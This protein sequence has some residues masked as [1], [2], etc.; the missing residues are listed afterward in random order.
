MGAGVIERIPDVIRRLGLSRDVRVVCD[1]CTYEV[2]GAGVIELLERAGI[3]AKAF[4]IA[5]ADRANI[6]R[7]KAEMTEG[8]LLVAVGGGRSIDVSKVAAFEL[9]NEFLSVP[10]A[11]S[12]DGIASDRASIIEADGTKRSSSAQPPIAV[13]ADL[14]VISRSPR[15]LWVSG[16]G[17]VVSNK[18]AVLDWKLANRI[19]G[20]YL[21]HYAA[22]LSELSA[23]VL[24]GSAEVVASGTP[25]GLRILV[26][27]LVLSSVAMSIGG[28]SR[29]ASGA[30]HLFS[31]T[32]DMIASSPAMHGEQCGVGA[33]IMMYLHGGDWKRIRD[34]LSTV[35]AP[36]DAVGLG[37]DEETIVEALVTAHRINPERYTILDGGIDRKAA[38]TACRVTGVISR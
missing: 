26:K 23:E 8:T 5:S 25:E 36:V 2:A 19:Q 33:I 30:E 35:G 27:S 21:S 22:T 34:A 14:A 24:I 3:P 28:S 20:E 32:L 11:A 4:I 17:D 6:E 9:G 37:M 18:T 29:P 16:F 12:H 15:R 31:H 10:T 7:L 1:Q 38:E 13:V